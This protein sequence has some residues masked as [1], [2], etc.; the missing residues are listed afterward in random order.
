MAFIA[1]AYDTDKIQKGR[2]CEYEGSRFLIARD[3]SD[4]YRKELG[5][6]I[7][8]VQ[9]DEEVSAAEMGDEEIRIKAAHLLLD[10][11]DVV[12]REGKEVPYSAE[13]AYLTMRH[14]K[15][16]HAWVVSQ[17]RD[18]AKYRHDALLDDVKKP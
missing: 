5:D 12:D 9:K 16:F 4:R 13:K 8:R 10:W 18:H 11:A 15:A 14:D 6:Y 2:W 17:A 3:D 7:R 1:D